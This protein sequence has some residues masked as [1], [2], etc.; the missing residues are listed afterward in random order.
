M[1]E[2][3]PVNQLVACGMLHDLGCK[4]ET[5]E[6]GKAALAALNTGIDLVLMDC[7][8]PEMDGYAATRAI[9]E[10]ESSQGLTPVPII[11]LTA[12]AIEGDR[13]LCLQSGMDDYVRKP[14]TKAQLRAAMTRLLDK[15]S[16]TRTFQ[17]IS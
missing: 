1:A 16:V 6:D 14:F 17:D 15:P 4:V 13:E 11:A 9:R 8:M 5:V 7:Q 10:R 2:D 3:N 12:N